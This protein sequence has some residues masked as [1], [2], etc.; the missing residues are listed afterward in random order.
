MEIIN[1]KFSYGENILNVSKLEIT[2]YFILN[3]YVELDSNGSLVTKYINETHN[4][5]IILKNKVFSKIYK[6]K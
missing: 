5:V 4:P 3:K 2:D 1:I 6:N